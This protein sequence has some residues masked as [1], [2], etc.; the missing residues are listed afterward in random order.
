[1]GRCL[2]ME[3]LSFTD[4]FNKSLLSIASGS[5][6]QLTAVD[7]ILNLLISF[8]VGMFIFFIYKKTFQGVLY[9]RSFNISLVIASTVTSLI[10]MTISGNLILSL[11][12]VGAL[13][14][15][16]FRTPIKDSM[17]LV[18]LFWAIS[19]GIANGVSYY[20]ISIIGSI[21]IALVILFLTSRKND[22]QP[23]L[24]IVQLTPE[25][26][27]NSVLALVEEGTTLSL[28]KSKIITAEFLELI[29]EVRIKSKDTD[30]VNQI[31]QM[32][33]T[34]KATL[35]SYAGDYASL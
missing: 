22:E 2:T 10:I 34:S 28:L 31:Q 21:V 8:L 3:P 27:E 5:I 6:D 11:G 20:N 13:S 9:Q 4:I 33:T 35:I 23:Y 18:F 29:L 19:V 7:I 12:M 30:F 1:M 25:S 17:D 32:P 24:L 26:D 14:I 16:R 15:V